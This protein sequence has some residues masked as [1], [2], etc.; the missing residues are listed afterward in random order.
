LGELRATIELLRQ[1]GHAQLSPIR[2]SQPLAV[3]MPF[4]DVSSNG[5]LSCTALVILPLLS[6]V[7]F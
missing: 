3:S 7:S 2:R 6:F 4:K 1:Q 5:R